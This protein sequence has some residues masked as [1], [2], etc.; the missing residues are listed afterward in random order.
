MLFKRTDVN[1]E[2]WNARIK[3]PN[4]RRYKFITLKTTNI[5]DARKLS[6]KLFYETVLKVE[7][8]QPIFRLSFDD[9]FEKWLS[10]KYPEWHKNN[11]KT[12]SGKGR[13]V[14]KRRYG[15]VLSQYE[16]HFKPM[17]GKRHMSTITKQDWIEYDSLRKDRRIGRHKKEVSNSTIRSEKST[18]WAFLKWCQFEGITNIK[19][20]ERDFRL[21]DLPKAVAR[22]GFTREEWK[23]LYLFLRKWVSEANDKLR[24]E[25][26]WTR[27]M[28]R[29][30]IFVMTHTG[31]RNSEARNLKWS[32]IDYDKALKR[33]WIKVSGKGQQRVFQAGQTVKAC[34]D[35][36]R[37]I[38]NKIDANDYVFTNYQGEQHT[39]L[40]GMTI[41][42]VLA[43]AGL[44]YS[45]D[46]KRRSTYSFR[47]TFATFRLKYGKNVSPFHLAKH[48][49]TS[50]AMI[51]QHY[52]HIT[53]TDIA[54]N[55][56]SNLR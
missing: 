5:E 17:Y 19:N 54:D 7:Q 10:E 44:T 11:K 32:D 34:F 40:Y 27:H 15:V 56:L 45:S 12:E 46:G 4:K 26:Y 49:G 43:K 23:K 25:H 51:D 35:R 48:M 1:N 28:V 21:K 6:I 52:G 3:I 37:A 18:L 38:S 14:T 41:R 36:I 2:R 31:M 50:I 8:N 13:Y 47:H 39:T 42:D 24:D 33:V 9:A 20:F 16:V 55:V 53:S 29:N 22:D 30:F